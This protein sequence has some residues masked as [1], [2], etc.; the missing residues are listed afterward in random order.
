MT[1]KTLMS[2]KSTITILLVIAVH[3]A[4]GAE[5]KVVLDNATNY[6]R[7]CQEPD[8]SFGRPQAH[9]RIGLTMLA[10]LSLEATP[11]ESDV[12][13]LKKG[14]K[15]LLKSGSSGGDL[16]DDVFNTESHAIALCAL[17]CGQEFLPEL[18]LRTEVSERIRRAARHLQRLQDRSTSSAARGGWKM[19][20]RKGRANDRR[21]SGWAL[22]AYQCGRLYGL[23]VPE[24]NAERALRFMLG[25]FKAESDKPDQVGGFSVDTEGLA[26][27]LISSMG[28]WV[29]SRFGGE[30]ES[31]K[32]N[33]A[34]LKRHPPSWSG[35]NYFFSAFFRTRV[36]KFGEP[37]G[38]LYKET[39]QRLL[40]QIADHQQSDGSV[41][42]PPGNAQNTVAMGPVFSTAMSILILNAADSRLPFD[43]DYRFKPRF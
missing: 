11:G 4:P 39:R 34:W 29:L 13:L 20:G 6:L 8:G 14:T 25:S 22:V 40:T 1:E 15:F 28:G 30:A 2:A 10:L 35:P 27:D 17:I 31:R 9:L 21:A 3:S 12:A 38:E 26:V 43:E 7:G 36:L 19:E 37:S 23:E 42:F 41:T 18:E 16:G 5:P 33:L 24:A 32:K